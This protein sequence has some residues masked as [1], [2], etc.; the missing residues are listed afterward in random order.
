MPPPADDPEDPLPEP[1]PLPPPPPD[2]GVPSGDPGQGPPATPT[3]TPST[4]GNPRTGA[5]TGPRSG[6]V[7]YADSWRLWWELN[8]EYML[9]LRGTIASKDVLSGGSSEAE[10]RA[11]AEVRSKVATA[12]R[13]VAGSATDRRVRAAAL[14]ALGRAG[15]ERDVALFLRVLRHP[16]QPTKVYEAAAIGLGSLAR[17]DNSA[18]R[19]EVQEFFER[20]LHDKVR[21][22]SH[23]RRLAI[24]AVSLR[25]RD[26]RMIGRLLAARL[27]T[28]LKSSESS[29]MLYACGLT[30]DPLLIPPLVEAVTS[31]KLGGRKLNDIAR[32]RAALGLAMT[33]D[34]TAVAVLARTLK[35]RRAQS[36]T[37]RSAVV[38]LGMLLRLDTLSEDQ[39][40]RG[41]KAILRAFG[42][43]KDRLVQGYAAVAMGAARTPFGVS[44]LRKAV[45][46]ADMTVRP[47]AAL[48]LGI[49][50]RHD[51]DNKALREFLFAKLRRSKDTERTAAL[52]IAVGL[53]GAKE[54]RD[55][56]FQ[57]LRRK[58][59]KVGV[60]APAIQGLGLLR[61]PSPEI[62][63]T[64]VAALDDGSHTVVED[65]SLALGFLGRRAT[66]R[67]LVNKLRKTK[68]ASVQV[69]MVAAL[70]HL[71]STV[72]IP[73]LLDVL[74][75]KTLKHTMRE[76]AASAL[77]ILVDDRKNDPL[78]EIDAHTN[79]YGLTNPG[80][81]LV[82]VY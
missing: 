78:F 67:L 73:S 50:S 44:L 79:P 40:A 14:R 1:I 8:R 31:G 63:S 10:T 75:D 60:R 5:R 3:P 15:N 19:G 20:L 17:V 54:A 7:S 13:A 49:A 22:P 27:A 74:S 6:G 23:S 72:A 11:R 4:P 59:L 28:K 26:D 57:C 30:R 52:S 25:G 82:I 70:S 38:G 47:Y 55:H 43:D 64:L 65:A 34:P 81:N 24:L 76:S 68:S 62:E 58:R 41:Q 37:R 12:L 39:R 69:H 61:Q 53:S 16:Q 35:S 36:H 45:D 42:R 80:R 32:G 46:D 21:M 2:P 51:R 71:G 56:L 66:A 48:A 77:G 9:G 18:L 29:T 33:L